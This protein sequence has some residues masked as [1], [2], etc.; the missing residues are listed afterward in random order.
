MYKLSEDFLEVLKTNKLDDISFFIRPYY[1][2]ETFGLFQRGA[3]SDKCTLNKEWKPA[4]EY[5]EF[6]CSDYI[7]LAEFEVIAEYWIDDNPFH[8]IV[9]HIYGYKIN[10]QALAEDI[11]NHGTDSAMIFDGISH[12][13]STFWANFK[14]IIN[15]E[16][17]SKYL[18]DVSVYEHRIY[19]ATNISLAE[20]L[21]SP[22]LEDLILANLIPNYYERVDV[23]IYSVIRTVFSTELNDKFCFVYENYD[24]RKHEQTLINELDYVV[25]QNKNTILSQPY[26]KMLIKEITYGFIKLE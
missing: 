26:V 1:D 4:D 17:Y 22:Q 24:Y 2:P 19:F 11:N 3:T 25:I 5:S 7:S 9:G 15:R 10:S 23:D 14:Y 18:K 8:E 20:E 21:K 16:A 6:E 12:I 13:L